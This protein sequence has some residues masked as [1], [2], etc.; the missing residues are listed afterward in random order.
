M[1]AWLKGGLIGGIINIFLHALYYVIQYFNI[2]SD[3]I[4]KLFL[5]VSSFSLVGE[6]SFSTLIIILFVQSFLIYFII[7][8]IIGLIISKLKKTKK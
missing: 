2:P 7:G 1:K 4:G 3:F 8:S 6:V 5:N